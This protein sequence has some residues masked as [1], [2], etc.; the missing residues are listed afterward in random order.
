M[1]RSI[2]KFSWRL[3]CQVVSNKITREEC[4]RDVAFL[5]EVSIRIREMYQDEGYGMILYLTLLFA[6]Y[7]HL[8]NRIL[9]EEKRHYP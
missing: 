9:G 3:P 5:Q 8:H 4:G 1:S 6:A 2:C 7:G